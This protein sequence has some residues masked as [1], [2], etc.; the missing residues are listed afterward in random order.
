MLRR[1]IILI[2]LTK[3]IANNVTVG[4]KTTSGTT[5][6]ISNWG[7]FSAAFLAAM[8]ATGVITPVTMVESSRLQRSTLFFMKWINRCF[9]FASETSFKLA[10]HACIKDFILYIYIYAF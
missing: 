10:K 3:K 9:L 8:A 7:T 5:L 2:S 4:T 6:I 1:R